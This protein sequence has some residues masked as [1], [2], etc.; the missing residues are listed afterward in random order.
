[1]SDAGKAAEGIDEAHEQSHPV[2]R[3]DLASHSVDGDDEDAIA[4]EAERDIGEARER[5]YEQAGGD[6]EHQ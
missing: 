2:C 4:V 1:M 3:I 5:P 6:D